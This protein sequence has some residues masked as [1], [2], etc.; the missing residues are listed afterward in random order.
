LPASHQGKHDAVL[1]QL[2]VEAA[3]FGETLGRRQNAGFAPG[4]RVHQNRKSQREFSCVDGVLSKRRTGALAFCTMEKKI[5][6][7]PLGRLGKPT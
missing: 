3:H 1:D 7:R 4:G 2:L 5:H 6:R